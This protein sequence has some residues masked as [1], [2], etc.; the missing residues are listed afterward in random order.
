MRVIGEQNQVLQSNWYAKATRVQ[1]VLSQELFQ[2]NLFHLEK[3]RLAIHLDTCNIHLSLTKGTEI[4]TDDRSCPGFPSLVHFICEISNSMNSTNGQ[5]TRDSLPGTW[6]HN[7][8]PHNLPH[9]F[10][11]FLSW[12]NHKFTCDLTC[13]HFEST[14]IQIHKR[15]SI[16]LEVCQLNDAYCLGTHGLQNHL[17]YLCLLDQISKAQRSYQNYSGVSYSPTL[18]PSRFW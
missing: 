8:M 13:S 9:A 10:R 18:M 15:E 1:N 16:I 4:N 3:A 5:K 2:N 14:K 12:T 11:C 6:N 17:F 7:P